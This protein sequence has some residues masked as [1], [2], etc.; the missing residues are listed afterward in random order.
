MLTSI[1]MLHIRLSVLT[2]VAALTLGLPPQV[3]AQVN[4]A[5]EQEL[6]RL[7]NQERARAKLPPWALNPQLRAA[8][9][10]HARLMAEHRGLSHK[11]ATELPLQE[12]LAATGLRSDRVAENVAYGESA[13]EAHAGLMESPPHRANILNPTYD[14]LGIG[15]VRSGD[16]LY[17]VE[18]FAHVLREY[19]S[20]ELE[21]IVATRGLELRFQAHLP[22]LPQKPGEELRRQACLMAHQD[23]LESQAILKLPGVRRAVT[24]TTTQPK[25]LPPSAREAILWPEAKAFAVGACFAR[26]PSAPGGTNWIALAIY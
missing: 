11:Y 15:V 17:V 14:T 6:F 16:L 22:R 2:L 1:P 13:A 10:A 4:A 5:A 7:L 9:R 3:A 12:R 21:K 25:D 8:A 20:P 18:D 23:K 19:S 26:S 24:F